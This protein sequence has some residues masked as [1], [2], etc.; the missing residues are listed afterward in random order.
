VGLT[1]GGG[2][3]RGLAHL[4]VLRALEE[5]RIPVDF[6]GG[7][8]MGAIVGAQWALGRSAGEIARR[9]SEGFAASFKDTTLPFVSFKRGGRHS[10]VIRQSFGEARIEDLW[11]PYFCVS[12]NLNRS[13]LKVHSAGPLAEAVTASSRAP[14]IFPPLVIDGELHIDGGVI[15]NVPV[16]VMRDFR[17]VGI[18]IGVDV[19]PP[20][21]LIEVANY[22]DEVS[23]WRAV[24]SRFN[25]NRKKRSYRPSILFV[26][27]RLIQFGGISYRRQKAEV[28]DVSISPDVARFKR[29]DFGAAVDLADAGYRAARE[30]LTK[31]LAEGAGELRMRRPD[32]FGG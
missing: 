12:T 7:S 28:A 21:E 10:R 20:D 27:K 3:A 29:D 26:L 25:P 6:I 18:V 4:G 11:L 8:S 30:A 2:F 22:G 9:T 16:D 32:L 24:W 5:L 19:S 1:L 23:G 14:G 17:G 15:N 13:E 31:W